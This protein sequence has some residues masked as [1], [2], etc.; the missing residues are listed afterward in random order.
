M[1]RFDNEYVRNRQKF[2][3]GGVTKD[4]RYGVG[5]GGPVSQALAV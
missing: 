4:I 5:V 3:N 1:N 2:V